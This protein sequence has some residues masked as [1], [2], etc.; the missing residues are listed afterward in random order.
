M[1]FPQTIKPLLDLKDCP[2]VYLHHCDGGH[3]ER[4]R[5]LGG[6]Q[7]LVPACFNYCDE[8][9]HRPDTTFA[10]V[11]VSLS[12]TERESRRNVTDYQDEEE[13][14]P[15]A[16]HLA[17]YVAIGLKES[18]GDLKYLSCRRQFSVTSSALAEHRSTIGRFEVFEV[19]YSFRM[20]CYSFK[21]HNG[22][23]LHY[24]SY[25]KTVAFKTVPEMKAQWKV[26]F[27]KR[28]TQAEENILCVAIVNLHTGD[29]SRV[30][31]TIAKSVAEDAVFDTAHF[32]HVT[33][34]LQELVSGP[35]KC[36]WFRLPDVQERWYVMTDSDCITYIVV[37]SE[38]YPGYL[39]TECNEQVA[40]LFHCRY[41]T[42]A[43][44]E[45]ERYYVNG[46]LPSEVQQ[47][48]L[49]KEVFATRVN[50]N[51]EAEQG[52]IGEE[53]LCEVK[54]KMNENM[55][56]LLANIESADSLL[57]KVNELED[58]TKVFRTKAKKL[59]R[60]MRNNYMIV[61]TLCAIAAGTLG[62]VGGWLAGGPA[63][64]AL[65]ATQ[66]T[67]IGFG[68]GAGAVVGFVGAS[69]YN[70]ESFWSNSFVPFR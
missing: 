45:K 7:G 43:K 25:F 34:L 47:E 16:L 19:S 21:S 18:N 50:F 67:E 6:K 49:A 33:R 29:A 53:G 42:S 51:E 39:A 40:A 8:V 12:E 4:G 13:R 27:A 38:G 20:G 37:T 30:P 35:K 60:Q 26:H 59:K 57:A 44:N 69:T 41:K 64:A 1:Q 36:T 23:Y 54:Q 62:G 28:F 56:A 15:F 58:Q 55:D 68:I 9:G 70:V 48:R 31:N 52:E 63:G 17:V 66:S 10:I 14:Q 11:P 61:P 32:D 22:L 65:L 5:L 2:E 24:N 3:M 46:N